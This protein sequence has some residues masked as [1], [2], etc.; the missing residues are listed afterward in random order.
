MIQYMPSLLPATNQSPP[1]YPVCTW[2]FSQSERHE[3]LLKPPTDSN[4]Y[5]LGPIG[6]H[7]IVIACLPKG[8]AGPNSAATVATQMVQTFPS[9]KIGLLVR[10]GDVVVSTPHGQFPEVVQWNL[11]KSTEGGKFERTGSLNNPPNSLLSALGKLE[12]KHELEGSK[13]PDFLEQ[14][15]E[16]YPLSAKSCLDSTLHKDVLFESGYSHVHGKPIEDNE[17]GEEEEGCVSC[18]PSQIVRRKHRSMSVHY[19]LIAPSI[20]TIEDAELRNR[21]N[22]ELDK[23]VLC[24]EME[25]AGLMNSFPC[26][27]KTWQKYAAAVVAAFAKELL[28][29]A[30]S[31]DVEGERP[32]RDV[33]NEDDQRPELTIL[34]KDELNQI[35]RDIKAGFGDTKK[36]LDNLIKVQK[37]QEQN[38]ALAWLSSVDYASMHHDYMKKCKPETGRDLLSSEE[39]QQW[40]NTPRT[41]LFCS[42]IPGAGKTLQTAI[43][44]NHL[45]NKFQHSDT[46]GLAFFYYRFDRQDTQKPELLIANFIKQLGQ[47]HQPS[48]EKI[49]AFYEDHEKKNGKPLVKELVDLLEGIISLLSR[50]YVIIDALDECDDDDYSRTR[51]LDN[52]FAMQ[53][54]GL[55]ICATSRNLRIIEQRFE[56]AIKWQV[57][58]STSDIF[59]FL[60]KRMAQLPG[61]VQRGTPL[62]EEIKECIE[63]AIEGMFLLAQVYIGSLIG[64]R[65]PASVRKALGGLKILSE[66][67][68]SRSD[69]LSTAYHK[70]MERIQQQKGDLPADKPLPLDTLRLILA[71]DIEASKIDK[72]N[73]PTAD[74]IIQACAPLVVI[75]S[76]TQEARLAHYTIQEYFER[77][78]NTWMEKSQKF[79]ANTCM[80]Y[81]SFSTIR[82]VFKTTID[83]EG[84]FYGYATEFWT[85]HTEEAL[86]VQGLEV[87]RAAVDLLMAQGAQQYEPPILS[88]MIIWL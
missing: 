28:G 30:Q 82:S 25:A 68:Q 51:L 78:N 42:G 70:A 52:L 65:S 81:L 76:K 11:G 71:I 46:I 79:I 44:I 63:S 15:R 61:F 21:L 34:L 54:K 77:S 50:A 31:S 69:V 37:V 1:S 55:N 48:R 43:F 85:Y 12:S 80:S 53:K 7:N 45:T 20:T 62:Q 47:N 73:F 58:P 39:F 60:G 23:K 84:K 36:D 56:G 49:Q 41:A 5:T 87:Q 27:N 9:I 3:G 16:K 26:I 2:P 19:G 88:Y 17:D 75:E 22:K 4:A 29:C 32:I 14:L 66:E 6:Q 83:D 57:V 38:E 10:L 35:N 24:V 33:L 74:Y 8:Y 13:I 72:D 67:I 59:S 64:K 40:I 86:L 18:D